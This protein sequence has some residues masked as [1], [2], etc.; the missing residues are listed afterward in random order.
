MLWTI[1]AAAV[2]AVVSVV[3][4]GLF[5]ANKP[6]ED[7]SRAE[8][9]ARAYEYLYSHGD[10]PVMLRSPPGGVPA[11]MAGPGGGGGSVP[12]ADAEHLPVDRGEGLPPTAETTRGSV[13]SF[14]Q[15]RKRLRN[16]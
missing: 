10:D 4:K 15:F 9:K 13:H 3:I 12:M 1:L 14:G 2:A 7:T 8:N 16:R 11:D 6:S 5:H